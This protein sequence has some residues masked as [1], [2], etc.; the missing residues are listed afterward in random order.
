MFIEFIIRYINRFTQI[1][2]LINSLI[3]HDLIC[4]VHLNRYNFLFNLISISGMS[5]DL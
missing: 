2:K 1:D 5:T 3:V 4:L